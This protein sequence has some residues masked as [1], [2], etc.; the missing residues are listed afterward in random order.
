MS[1]LQYLTY[2]WKL[3]FY[4]GEDLYRNYLYLHFGLTFSLTKTYQ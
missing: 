3:L 2:L 4:G 1:I